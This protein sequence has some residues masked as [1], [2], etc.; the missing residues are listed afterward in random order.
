MKHKFSVYVLIYPRPDK[1]SS[2]IDFAI[3]RMVYI[4]LSHTTCTCY[5]DITI[6]HNIFVAR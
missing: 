1:E 4:A 3:N 5:N 2:K 6:L